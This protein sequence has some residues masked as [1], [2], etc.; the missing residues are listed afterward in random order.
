MATKVEDRVIITIDSQYRIEIDNYHNHTLYKTT[1]SKDKEGNLNGNIQDTILGY[2]SS[3]ARA[4]KLWLEDVAISSGDTFDG[5]Q[6]YI[7][8]L[9]DIYSKIDNKLD[10][11]AENIKM[12]IEKKKRGKK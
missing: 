6:E 8:H 10:G 2:C 7:N 5:V 9:N 4:L 12:A 11:V 1:A 3:V